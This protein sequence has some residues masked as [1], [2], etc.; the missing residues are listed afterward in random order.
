MRLIKSV[1][2]QQF[3]NLGSISGGVIKQMQQQTGLSGSNQ[4]LKQL[5]IT[6][7]NSDVFRE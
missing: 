7:L 6:V 2:T 3:F 4:R 5:R 1:N